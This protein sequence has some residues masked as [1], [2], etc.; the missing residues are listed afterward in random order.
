MCGFIIGYSLHWI[1]IWHDNSWMEIW[2]FNQTEYDVGPVNRHKREE[3]G[4]KNYLQTNQLRSVQLVD[5]FLGSKAKLHGCKG[6]PSLSVISSWLPYC[7]FLKMEWG[8]K[9]GKMS[10]ML[11]RMNPIDYT[12]SKCSTKYVKHRCVVMLCF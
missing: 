8:S 10:S 4:I 5:Y 6:R 1:Q 9:K 11:R 3:K 7:L 12:I 2:F